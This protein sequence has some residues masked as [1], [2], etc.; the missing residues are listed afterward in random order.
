MH[1]FIDLLREKHEK[2]NQQKEKSVE[3]KKRVFSFFKGIAISFDL[4]GN[5]RKETKSERRMPRLSGG[6]EGR[7]KLRKV[8]GICKQDLIRE[9]PNGA[10]HMA[11]GHVP[12]RDGANPGN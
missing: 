3:M 11:E 7:G 1:Q 5:F 10:T 6:E 8:A 4:Q 2:S 9:C 12:S